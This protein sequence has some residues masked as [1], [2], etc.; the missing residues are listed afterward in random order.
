MTI[1]DLESLG[2]VVLGIYM[3]AY[4]AIAVVGDR[5]PLGVFIIRLPFHKRLIIERGHKNPVGEFL[6]KIRS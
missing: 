1:S 4:L 3:L 5:A 2:R 6:R